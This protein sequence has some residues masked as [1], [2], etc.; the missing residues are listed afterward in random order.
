VLNFRYPGEIE[1][2]GQVVGLAIN[3]D[4]DKQRRTRS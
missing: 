4:P 1:V 3:L 2:V